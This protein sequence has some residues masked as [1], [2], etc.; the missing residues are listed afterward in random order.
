MFECAREADLGGVES[1]GIF[2]ELSLV[3][4][5]VLDGLYTFRHPAEPV[6]NDGKSRKCDTS[7]LETG[8]GE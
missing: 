6:Y 7:D 4:L 3:F 1:E 2:I 8:H 5:P